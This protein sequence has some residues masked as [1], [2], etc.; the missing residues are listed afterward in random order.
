MVK[1]VSDVLLATNNCLAPSNTNKKRVVYH[2]D[3]ELEAEPMDSFLEGYDETLF[4]TETMREFLKAFL[5]VPEAEAEALVDAMQTAYVAS[6]P[7]NRDDFVAT[8]HLVQICVPRAALDRFAYP[9]V[10]WGFPVR[11][12]KDQE[13]RTH[14]FPEFPGDPRYSKKVKGWTASS[15]SEMTPIQQAHFLRSPEMSGLQTR[16][17]GHPNLYLHQ[18]AVCNVFHANPAFDPR[19]FRGRMLEILEPLVIQAR[20]QPNKRLQFSKFLHA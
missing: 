13:G 4:Y 1:D 6:L 10:S 16:I 3:H 5:G 12:F 11:L 19:A 20:A 7:P 15:T 2:M 17:I 9:S 8:G 18:G 14:T